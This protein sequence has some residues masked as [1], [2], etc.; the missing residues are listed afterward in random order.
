MRFL[1]YA[2]LME[3]LEA[4]SKRYEKTVLIA[5]Q[6]ENISD[7]DLEIFPLALLGSFFPRH[8]SL[9]TGISSK[10]VLKAMAKSFGKDSSEIEKM[11]GKQGDL[12]LV[13]QKL[14]SKG[15]QNTLFSKELTLKEVYAQL[16]KFPVITGKG[17]I[18]QKISTLTGLMNKANEKEI[19]FLVRLLI[20]DLRSGVGDGIVRDALILAY[21]MKD[22][23]KDN[24]SIP[25]ELQDKA[26][27]ALDVTNDI[28]EFSLLIKKHPLDFEN[29]YSLK[30]FRPLKSML[31]M[32]S[33]GLDDAIEN[34]KL[35]C[36]LEHKY[37]GFRVQI[38]KKGKEVRLFTRRLEDVTKQFSE[39]IAPL[40]KA[41]K[42]DNAVLDSE[43]IG[44]DKKTGKLKPF[45]EISQRIKRKYDI[46]KIAE[47]L[48]V[49]AKIFD[50]IY[51][52][53]KSMI[54]EPFTKR[55]EA[56]ESAINEEKDSVEISEMFNV[57]TLGEAE[58]V[59]QEALDLGFEG[60]MAKT[61]DGIYKP[62]ARVGYMIKI[63]P[64][65]ETMD[66][67]IVGG[68]YGEGKRATWI[69]S[70]IVAVRSGDKYLTVGK[71]ASG[72][73]EKDEE[74]FSFSQMTEMLKEI[75]TKEKGR[76]VEVKPKIVVEVA[77]EE[78]QSSDAY[79]S[80][81]ALRFPRIIRV[82]QDKGPE[83]ATTLDEIK[84]V[85]ESQRGR[86]K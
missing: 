53:S 79:E 9:E 19:K 6:L 33:K 22:Y 3:K 38:H 77:A 40:K 54:N 39:M 18:D 72:L 41:I 44:Y 70:Y 59:Y 4:V 69:S 61:P 36:I 27:S 85:Y 55:R 42:I 5:E 56:L 20:G 28:S 14:Q 73:K 48:P 49:K 23:D 29:H 74:G 46:E 12:G 76:L 65:L 83:D 66:V 60:C 37:D 45:Q 58:K 30:L 75:I 32:R 21:I 15:R 86:N 2:E 64:T 24:L 34:A 78:V 62:G 68:E 25:R 11:W 43:F 17:S 10:L 63:K 35:P 8:S 16:R 82:R 80:K 1:Q 7:S 81:Y 26:Q 84:A 31:A 51:S 71:V 67:V 57:K 50:I 47:K 13:V 52:D